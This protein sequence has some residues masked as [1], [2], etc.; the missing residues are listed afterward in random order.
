MLGYCSIAEHLNVYTH[1]LTKMLCKKVLLLLYFSFDSCK[2]DS[3]L[4][5]KVKMLFLHVSNPFWNMFCQIFIESHLNVYLFWEEDKRSNEW[6]EFFF[7][8]DSSSILDHN[9]TA[10]FRVFQNWKGEQ[11]STVMFNKWTKF[12][13]WSAILKMH[14]FHHM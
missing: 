3:V 4:C 11:S 12:M 10:R 7:G 14:C 2:I 6:K 13:C 8:H 9:R 1:A 5:V